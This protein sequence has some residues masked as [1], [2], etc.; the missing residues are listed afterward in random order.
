MKRLFWDIETTPC[1]GYFWRPSYRTS[2]SY[3]N[4][5]EQAK[6]ICISYKWQDEDEVHTLVWDGKDDKKLVKA[7]AKELKKSDDAV[8]HNGDRFDLP[9][10]KTRFLVH[11]VDFPAKITT[12]DTLKCARGNFRFPS[13]RL[14]DI[15]E[16][17][18]LGKKLDTGGFGL[19]KDVMKGDK[20]ALEKMVKYCEQ[21]VLLLEKVYYKLKNHVPVTLH[22]GVYNGHDKWTCPS[23][24]SGRVKINKKKV[25]ATGII[26]RQLKCHDCN[27]Y[28]TI[29]NKAYIDYLKRKK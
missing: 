18:G 11:G 5:L 16:Y 25:T 20:K 9:W 8:A 1:I 13:N 27:R 19:W 15:G 26:K 6:I 17:L 21:D 23:C 22:E 2:I 4:I 29:S 14:N 7:F 10:V 12:I 24:S 28:Y 3:D